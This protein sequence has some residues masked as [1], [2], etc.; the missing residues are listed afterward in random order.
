MR[1]RGRF[2]LS[3]R[4]RED[5]RELSVVGEFEIQVEAVD[6]G[7]CDVEDVEPA[8]AVHDGVAERG[9]GAGRVEHCP[10]K[11]S[12][13]QHPREEVHHEVHERRAR[14]RGARS[15]LKGIKKHACH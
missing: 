8:E 12:R 15:R 5:V 10:V 11:V 2:F 13:I 1:K 14:R 3:G 4:L 7:S 9:I 6:F